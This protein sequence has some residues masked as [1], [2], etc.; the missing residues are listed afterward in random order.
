MYL[1]T[2]VTALNYVQEITGT[3]RLIV[4][5]GQLWKLKAK[6][7]NFELVV[8]THKCGA[9]NRHGLFD[10]LLCSTEMRIMFVQKSAK[11]EQMQ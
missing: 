9:N 11:R 7:S 1:G 3:G 5:C 8:T 10:C 6:C 4:F 2:V